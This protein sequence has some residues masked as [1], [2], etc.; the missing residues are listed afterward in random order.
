M[1]TT[2]HLPQSQDVFQIAYA[3]RR[4]SRAPGAA[5]GS[6]GR[7]GGQGRGKDADQEHCLDGTLPANRRARMTACSSGAGASWW[8]ATSARPRCWRRSKIAQRRGPVASMIKW[9][10]PDP[11]GERPRGMQVRYDPANYGSVG[12]GGIPDA[13]RSTTANV[14]GSRAPPSGWTLPLRTASS[15]RSAMASSRS[16][17]GPMTAPA[18]RRARLRWQVRRRQVTARKG[19][20]MCPRHQA[21]C[22]RC[23]S[24]SMPTKRCV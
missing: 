1:T 19:N 6:T 16:F 17:S 7:G 18:A 11:T 10:F 15:I 13:C 2:P 4:S 21:E 5:D 3:S 24:V 23:A 8:R 12:R 22:L 9:Y 20:E 14:A